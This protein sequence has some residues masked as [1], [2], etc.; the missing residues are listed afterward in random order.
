LK[1]LVERLGFRLEGFS[2]RYLKIGGEWRDHDRYALL[3]DESPSPLVGEGVGG[4][5]G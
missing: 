1:A 4:A 2:P 5:D 3:A